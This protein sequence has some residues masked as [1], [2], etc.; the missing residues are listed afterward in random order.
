M[1]GIISLPICIAGYFMLPDLPENTRAFY[2]N[3]KVRHTLYSRSEEG[4]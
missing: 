1:D 4:T 3:E 2:L